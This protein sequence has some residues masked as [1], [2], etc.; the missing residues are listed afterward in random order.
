MRNERGLKK[1]WWKNEV[2]ELA[3][4]L[5]MM[6]LLGMLTVWDVM[7]MMAMVLVCLWVGLCI[8]ES[9]KPQEMG[10]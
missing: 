5:L 8:G 7:N 3:L 1:R 2:V 10:P 4:L 9:R 6:L